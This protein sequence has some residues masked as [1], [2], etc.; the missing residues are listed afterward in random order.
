MFRLSIIG[1]AT[2]AL[3]GV[4]TPARAQD[5]APASALSLD[6]AYKG[7]VVG[8]AAGET[9]GARY[10]DNLDV[11]AALDLDR[12]VGWRG[13]SAVV[14]LLNNLGGRPNDLAGTLQGVDNIEVGAPGLLLYQA[15]FQQSFADDRLS[16]LVGKYDLNSEFY[17]GDAAAHLIAPAFGIG[18]ELAATGPNGPSIFPRTDLAIR[19]RAGDER[20]Y[21]Q[22]VAIRAPRGTADTGRERSTLFV[23]EGGLQGRTA[24]GI[25]GWAYS[26][27]QPRIAPPGVTLADGAAAS[28]GVYLLLERDLAGEA[29]KPGHW[30]AF[31]RAGLSDGRTTPF[32]GGFQIGLTGRGIVPARPDSQVSIGMA[33]ADLST[34]YRRA[35]PAGEPA[36]T[37]S[38][39]MIELTYS[40]RIAPFLTLQPDVQY[41]RRPGGLRDVDDALVLGLRAIVAWKVL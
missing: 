6:L 28:H 25:G 9:R 12:A 27:R 37:G 1:L 41:V 35:N 24:I 4:A 22:A 10:L 34:P 8:V 39:G 7:D 26:R 38:E 15:W 17:A 16:I 2:L 3:T 33:S 19:L 20:H 21:V 18:S 14:S 23:A 29:D 5:D 11:V 36:L 32:A 13:G 31:A 30:R 40:D